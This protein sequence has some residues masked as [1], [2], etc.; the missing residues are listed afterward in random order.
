MTLAAD[1]LSRFSGSAP[2]YPLY[3]P[4]LTLWYASHRSRG[5]LPRR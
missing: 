4:D 2:G 5:T 3:V 1:M